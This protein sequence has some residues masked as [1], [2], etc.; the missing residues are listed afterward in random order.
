MPDR[1]LQARARTM[2]LAPTPAERAVWRILRAAPFDALHFRRQVPFANRYI[3]DFASHRANVIIEIDG[4]THDLES[5]TERARTAWLEAQGYRMLRYNNSHVAEADIARALIA[6]LGPCLPPPPPVIAANREWG[7]TWGFAGMGCPRVSTTPTSLPTLRFAWGEGAAGL[8]FITKWVI[9][10]PW[11]PSPT[12]PS[13]AAI[14]EMAG[15]LPGNG[16]SSRRSKPAGR[17]PM[18]PRTSG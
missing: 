10:Y 13:P 11:K 12:P 8:H 7:G 16:R 2:R 6:A 14:V 1:P 15:P 9:S 3:A 5:A 17:S 18:R 4:G